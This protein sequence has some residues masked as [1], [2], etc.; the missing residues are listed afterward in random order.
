MILA[1]SA[2]LIATTAATGIYLARQIV[3]HQLDSQRQIGQGLLNQVEPAA[4]VALAGEA[5]A[6]ALAASLQKIAMDPAVASLRIV[7]ANGLPLYEHRG[8]QQ[9]ANGFIQL[10]TGEHR[11][12]TLIAELD[13]PGGERGRIELG[14]SYQSFNRT[15]NQL[16]VRVGLFVALALIASI[17][18]TYFLLKRFTAPLKPLTALAQQF[19]RGNWA[20]KV[21]LMESGTHEIQQLNQALAQ[22]SAAMR[23]YIHNLEET[24]ELLEYNEHRLRTLINSMHEILFELDAAGRI[25]FLNPAWQ[26]LTGFPIDE[27][28]GRAFTDF[29]M[30]E[31]VID[32]FDLEFLGEL[33]EKNREI[34][35]RT[36]DG[37]GLWASLDADAHQDDSGRFSGIIGTLS[38]ITQS[39]ELNTLLAR[40]RDDLYV[41]SVTDPLTNLYN[42]RH[43]DNQLDVVLS[44]RLP[45]G[46]SVCL[47]I[48]DLDGFK[49]INDTYGHPA[50]DQALRTIA[51]LLKTAAREDDYL[52]RLAGDEFAMVLVDTNLKTAALIAAKLH[53]G[54]NETRIELPIGDIQL[55]CSIGVAEAPLHGRNL[56]ELV[57]AADVA[58]YQSKRQG[59][60]RVEVLSADTSETVMTI[61]NQGFQLRNA[62]QEGGLMPAFQPICDMRT[63]Q[64]VAYEALARM[65]INNNTIQA[66]EFIGVAEELGLTREIDLHIIEQSLRLAPIGY[67]L[68]LNL[69]PSSFNDRN[70]V[71]QL[72]GL[73]APAC[74]GG[75]AIT[76]EITERENVIIT[77]ALLA[78]I[79]ELRTLGCKLALDDFGSGYST[80]QFLNLFRPEYLKIEGAFVRGMLDNEADRKIVEHIHDLAVAFG[81]STIAESVENEDTC[82]ALLGMGIH[83]AQGFH[84]GSPQLHPL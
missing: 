61:F 13:L 20:T 36:A 39:V 79:G 26:Q 47:L 12:P 18:V 77:D 64:P 27:A 17:A 73:L 35:M 41:L 2:L 31:D 59:R 83:N 16:A 22:G 51:Q 50:G 63:G 40:Y 75:R 60:N 65:R 24:R 21:T 48:I 78:D 49:F 5:A 3:T 46:Q 23:H 81:I 66:A 70:F 28:M 14:L 44:E 37:R 57:S 29:L 74:R 6:G 45:L 42:R 34:R 30:D 52:A 43:F 84:L 9:P 62:L 15:V 82:Q 8:E 33:R 7:D 4:H 38:D 71:A 19:A 67:D 10:L 54:I 32:D 68:F 11:P 25:S 55:R 72:T 69:D 1:I 58:L 76:I 80:Y 53:A 56:Q